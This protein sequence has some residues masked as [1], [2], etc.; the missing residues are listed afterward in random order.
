[1]QNDEENQV[2][3]PDQSKYKIILGFTAV[4]LIW[5]STYLAIRFG[6]ET[7]PPF[8]LAG[9]RFLTGG[10]LLYAWMRLRGAERPSPALWLPAVIIGLLMPAGGTGLITWAEKTVPSGLTALLVATAPM[11]IILVDWFRPSG[12]KPTLLVVVGLIIGFTGVALLINPTDIG[13]PAEINKLGAFVIIIATLSWAIGSIYSRHARQPRSKVLA[14]GMQMI[15]GGLGCIL[16]SVLSGE[17]TAFDPYAVSLKSLLALGYL[18]SMGS[19]AFVAYVWL[20]SATTAARVS[21]YAYVNPVIALFL[22]SLIAGE[23][24][25][26]WTLGCSAMIII[27]VITIIIARTRLPEISVSVKQ[28]QPACCLDHG[29]VRS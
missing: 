4:Y 17:G 15:T 10:L 6:V 12:T 20:L 16:I 9:I 7:I 3:M 25:T 2:T 22:G 29:R 1:M 18:I 21:T 28:E 13:R 11:W 8:M 24:L 23:I 5:G 19:I 14:T 27:A 26:Y